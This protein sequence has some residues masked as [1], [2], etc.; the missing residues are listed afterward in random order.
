MET[1]DRE[2]QDRPMPKGIG[3]YSSGR[4]DISE[5]LEDLLAERKGTSASERLKAVGEHRHG[6]L[7]LL[8]ADG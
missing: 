5:R 7:I 2:Y 8:P 3:S 6:S 1:T 4:V